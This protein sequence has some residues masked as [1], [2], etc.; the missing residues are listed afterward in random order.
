M[1]KS[2]NSL[3]SLKYTDTCSLTHERKFINCQFSKFNL[4]TSQ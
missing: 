3:V 2:Q 1:L 4:L